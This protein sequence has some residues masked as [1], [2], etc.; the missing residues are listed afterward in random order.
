MI[1]LRDRREVE[2]FLNTSVELIRDCFTKAT[3]WK[4]DDIVFDRVVKVRISGVPF[5]LRDNDLYDRIGGL[6]GRVVKGSEFSWEDNNNLESS[7]TVL[8]SSGKKI[9]EVIQLV[10]NN[11]TYPVWIS[12]MTESWLPILDDE[13]FTAASGY[14]WNNVKEA[15]M[16]DETEEGEIRQESTPEK[17][18]GN[19]GEDNQNVK[20]RALENEEAT[21]GAQGNMHSL[22]GEDTGVFGIPRE[23]AADGFADPT[24]SIQTPIDDGPAVG[25]NNSNNNNRP[26]PIGLSKL[27]GPTPLASLGKRP[28]NIRSPPSAGSTQGPPI[29][30]FF[31]NITEDNNYTDLN[32]PAAASS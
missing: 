20:G 18:S 2:M 24:K 23:V 26:H 21:Q 13:D 31:Q 14:D 1:V 9:E 11:R 3:L 8:V 4:G 22:H 5:R 6:V 10:W 29:K 30:T 15:T 27:Q 17:K 16:E 25:S 7:C 32:A 28:R 12:E 19:S